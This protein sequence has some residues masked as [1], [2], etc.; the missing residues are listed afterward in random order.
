MGILSAKKITQTFSLDI[1]LSYLQ[2]VYFTFAELYFLFRT[3]SP[4]ISV[5]KKNGIL[6]LWKYSTQWL[7]QRWRYLLP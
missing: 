4:C 5:H 7:F 3:L 6:D 1:W 2:H